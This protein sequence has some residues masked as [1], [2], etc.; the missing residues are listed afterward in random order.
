[1][2]A[3][4]RPG[5]PW[6]LAVVPSQVST[7]LHGLPGAIV[8]YEKVRDLRSTDTYAVI[9]TTA[10]LWSADEEG[11]LSKMGAALDAARILCSTE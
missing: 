11:P 8:E 3:A 5:Y 1:M 7:W 10:S 9:A 6:Y 2:S 4:D